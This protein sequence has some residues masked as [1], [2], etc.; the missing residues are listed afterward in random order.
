M[1]L[2]WHLAAKTESRMNS[3]RHFG[4]K[5]SGL[6]PLYG[7]RSLG[8]TPG[9]GELAG[10]APAPAPTQAQL[11]THCKIQVVPL[12]QGPQPVEAAPLVI[13]LQEL[14]AACRGS[15]APGL[16]AWCP[17]KTGQHLLSAPR[18]GWWVFTGQRQRGCPGYNPLPRPTHHTQ[19]HTP[20][21][22][23]LL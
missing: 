4:I 16:R 21:G 1:Q 23:N 2:A 5:G 12:P 9:V 11:L 7:R 15:T 8:R 6:A 14:Y 17:Q 13:I 20:F 18:E 10:P 19:T 22:L 3:G